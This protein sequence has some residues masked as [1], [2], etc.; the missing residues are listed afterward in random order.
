MTLECLLLSSNLKLEDAKAVQ[1][2]IETL[3]LKRD[4]LMSSFLYVSLRLKFEG[5]DEALKQDLKE[6]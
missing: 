1:P 3:D 4:Y 2:E 6:F 5:F